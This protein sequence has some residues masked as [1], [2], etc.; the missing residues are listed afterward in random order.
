M[1]LTLIATGGTIASTHR[2]DGAST[3]TLSTRELLHSIDIATPEIRIVDLAPRD[4][5]TMTL[6]DMQH[7]SDAVRTELADPSVTAIVATHGTDAMAETAMLLAI[8]HRDDRPIILT[9]AQRTADAVEPDGPTNLRAALAAATDNTTRGRGVLVAMGRT[10]LPAVGVQKRHTTDIDGFECVAGIP[11]I[12]PP[13]LTASV[14]QM[15]IDVVY[16][17]PG[18]DAL[19]L[20]TSVAAGA[21]GI[22]L[23][24]LGAGNASPDV[25]AAVAD[26]VAVG[27]PVIT[28]SHTPGGPLLDTYGGG[29]GGHDLSAAGAIVSSW[30]R[31]GQARI[32]LA[33]LIASGA[34]RRAIR[35]AFGA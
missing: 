9:G 5:S 21:D 34:D 26:A 13:H 19:H 33:A 23:A 11:E 31:P 1:A 7:V 12:I 27:V 18:A 17:H 25:V 30:L 2:A 24:G 14:A 28:S 3:P 20:R 29:G 16:I 22:V 10:L 35:V 15:R 4:S 32:L 6:A 8:A